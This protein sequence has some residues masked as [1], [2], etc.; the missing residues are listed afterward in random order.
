[1]RTDKNRCKHT[2]RDAKPSERREGT[3]HARRKAKA[4]LRNAN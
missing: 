3:R 4:D 1:M 2:P